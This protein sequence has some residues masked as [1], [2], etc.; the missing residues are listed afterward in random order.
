MKFSTVYPPPIG[1]SLEDNE[2][3]WNVKFKE[4]G[5]LKLLDNKK[6]Y[7]YLFYECFYGNQ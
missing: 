6:N 2:I 1:F 4:N 7:P 5:N 3:H